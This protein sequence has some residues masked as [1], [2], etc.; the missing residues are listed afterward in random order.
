MKTPSS[1]AASAAI[2][3]QEGVVEHF[4]DQ[5]LDAR[6]DMCL[7]PV[8]EIQHDLDIAKAKLRR[9]QSGQR[10]QGQAA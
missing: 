10:R 3:K 2:V 6:A 1:A 5:L 8:A 9:L 7:R 4:Q